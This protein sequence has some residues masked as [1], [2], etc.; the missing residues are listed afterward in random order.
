MALIACCSADEACICVK[1]EPCGGVHIFDKECP[2]HVLKNRDDQ[3]APYTSTVH[4]IAERSIKT[5]RTD[6]S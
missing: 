3:P 6:L 1:V 5:M 2:Q 4:E